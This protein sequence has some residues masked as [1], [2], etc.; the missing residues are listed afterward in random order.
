MRAALSF[1]IAKGAI[2]STGMEVPSPEPARIAVGKVNLTPEA[3]KVVFVH[4]C[5]IPRFVL[6]G[7]SI[8]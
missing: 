6:S 8:C 2:A 4:N 1:I 3:F 5:I 7:G